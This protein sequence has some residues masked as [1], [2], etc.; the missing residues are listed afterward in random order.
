[1]GEH[2]EEVLRTVGGY[3]GHEIEQLKR[4]EII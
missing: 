3:S 1:M 4:E 2:T